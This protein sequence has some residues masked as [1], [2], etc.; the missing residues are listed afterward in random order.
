M[1]SG[2]HSDH[3]GNRTDA[4]YFGGTAVTEQAVAWPIEA[5]PGTR[6]RYA[7]N[8]TLLAIRGLRAVLEGEEKLAFPFTD[9]L[10]KIG[11][12]RTVPETDWRGN[13]ILS[14]QVWTDRKRQRLE[15][16]Q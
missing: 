15:Y 2:L 3:A 16:S 6:W 14:S 8:D 9:L 1:A 4:L 10:W 11:M 12:T 13:F 5:A 7:N